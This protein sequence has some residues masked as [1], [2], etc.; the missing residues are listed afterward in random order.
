M[1]KG[2][3]KRTEKTRKKISEGRLKRKEKF[4]YL[5]SEKTKRK[6]SE[7]K[8]GK[9]FSEEIREKLSL[10]HKGEKN[11]LYG[12]HLFEETKRK[13]GLANSIANKG[14]KHSE[15]TKERM[16]QSAFEYAK[17]VDG[18]ICPTIGRNE[19]Q[20]LDELEV[21]LEYRIIRQYEVGGYHLDG[22]IP[23]INLAIEVDEK[24]HERIKEKDNQREEFIKQKLGCR[25]LR[26][27]DY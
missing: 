21:K 9:K 1:P 11:Y 20:K 14:K 7:A 13:I 12:K 6:M 25:F 23:E 4:G 5:N 15:E 26:I 17:K 24:R 2:I 22:Y 19:K 16:R 3:Y 10:S 8:K 27:K 18:I